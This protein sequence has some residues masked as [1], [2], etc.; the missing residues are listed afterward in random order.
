[1]ARPPASLAGAAAPA[2]AAAHVAGE[3]GAAAGLALPAARR[4]VDAARVAASAAK[5][6]AGG[7]QGRAEVEVL[8]HDGTPAADVLV[9]VYPHRTDR[10]EVEA[11]RVRT[12]ARGVA[13]VEALRPGACS[14]RGDRGG[15]DYIDVVA[16]ETARA[17]LHLERGMDIHGRVLDERGR[18]VEGATVWISASGNGT[19]GAPLT[20]TDAS[21][22][23]FVRSITDQYGLCARKAGYGPSVMLWCTGGEGAAVDMEL[24]L[25]DRA[26]AMRLRAVDAAGE[27]IEGAV[28]RL[29]GED[30]P[31][32]R[33]ETDLPLQRPLPVTLRTD[34]EGRCEAT[35][36][37]PGR[38]ELV[39]AAPVHAPLRRWIDVPAGGFGEA[40]VTLERGLTVAGTVRSAEGEPLQG[41]FVMVGDYGLDSLQRRTDADGAFRLEHVASGE[42]AI[43]ASSREQGRARATLSGEEGEVLVWDAVLDRGRVLSARLVDERGEPLAGWWIQVAE[44]GDPS[45]RERPWGGS[46]TTDA[47][48]RLRILRCPAGG[49]TVTAFERRLEGRMGD[50]TFVGLHADVEEHELVVP[51]ATRGR[52]TLLGRVLD[53]DGRPVSMRLS[54]TSV[55]SGRGASQHSHHAT[56]AFR[57]PHLP[58]GEYAVAFGDWNG[59]AMTRRV[60]LEREQELDLGDVQPSVGGVVVLQ[61]AASSGLVPANVLVTLGDSLTGWGV[62]SGSLA[63]LAGEREVPA[64]HYLLRVRGGAVVVEEHVVEVLPGGRVE[65]TLDPVEGVGLGLL[66]HLPPDAEAPGEL[67][68]SVTAAGEVREYTLRVDEMG[69]DVFGQLTVPSADAYELRF[70]GD[71]LVGEA[72]FGADDFELSGGQRFAWTEVTLRRP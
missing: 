24:L 26:G 21:G 50:A 20:T 18:A 35:C 47:D 3:P 55:S 8:W 5:A 62:L 39:V 48:G 68:A 69:G 28:M 59:P 25:A 54:L 71:G 6:E 60:R 52:S 63:D 51:E 58:A 65:L 72:W 42:V 49:L 14:F 7:P 15:F 61:L 57:F 12:G 38:L 40:T 56:G 4:G 9:E 66:F 33:P 22:A 1:A 31:A 45:N 46:A 34:A 11:F 64:G 36:L 29:H 41:V 53:E 44:S 19:Q 2:P 27:P 13:R 37:T 23:F 70:S 43:L 17:T 10:L 32:A 67:R 30:V 16:G